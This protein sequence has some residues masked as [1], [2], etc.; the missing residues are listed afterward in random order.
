M[1]C[2]TGADKTNLQVW[3]V[4]VHGAMIILARKFVIK[5]TDGKVRKQ[6][7]RPVNG[8]KTDVYLIR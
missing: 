3:Q 4:E 7:S 5:D 6:L 2:S 1:Q 8:K